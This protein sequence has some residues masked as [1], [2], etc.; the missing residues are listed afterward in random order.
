MQSMISSVHV[1]LAGYEKGKCF[2]RHWTL[3]E[4]HAPKEETTCSLVCVLQWTVRV[5]GAFF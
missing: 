5:A 1:N 2:K 4:I 3:E